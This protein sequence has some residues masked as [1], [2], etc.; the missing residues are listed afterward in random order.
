MVRTPLAI[1]IFLPYLLLNAS[2]H[3]VDAPIVECRETDHAIDVSVHG[4]PVLRYHK[5]VLQPPA[6]IDPVFARSGFIHPVWTPE[7]KVVT[8]DFPADHAHQHG[9]F[10]AWV[11]TSFNGH[12]VD[13]WNQAGRAGNVEHVRVVETRSGDLA[14][15]FTVE[16]RHVDLTGSDGP[17]SVL[18]ELWAVR[19]QPHEGGHLFDIESRQT[20]VADVPLTV[21]EYHYGGMAFRGCDEWFAEGTDFAFITSDGKDRKA[22]NHTRPGWVTAQGTI[23]GKVRGLMVIDHVDNFRAPQP[24]RLHPTK[25]YFVYSPCVLGEFKLEPGVELVNR[26]RYFVCDAAIPADVADELARDF[27]PAR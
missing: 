4:K 20:C 1:A 24:V 22:A 6:G 14:G 19:I 2:L 12:K 23:D 8:A 26:Y 21:H 15:E 9:L 7:G 25:P 18:K 17:V 16:L 11:N 5:S 27:Q 3:A 10:S 13:F